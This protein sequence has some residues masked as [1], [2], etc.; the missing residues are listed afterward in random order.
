LVAVVVLAVLTI[1]CQA[2]VLIN[3]MV[4]Q[5][6]M[7]IAVVVDILNQETFTTVVVVEELAV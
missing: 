7:V 5:I 1:T 4:T 2:I 6:L 3:Q